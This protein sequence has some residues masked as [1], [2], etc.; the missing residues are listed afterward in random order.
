MF[1]TG[2]EG[3]ARGDRR[4]R[5]RWRSSAGP[6]VH[7]RNGVCQ[8]ARRRRRRRRSARRAT[9]SACCRS[10]SASRR[11]CPTRLR[12]RP[13]TR[14]RRPARGAQGLRRPRRRRAAIFDG[15]SLLELCAALGAEHGHRHSPASR[16]GRSA[17]SPTSRSHLGGVIDAAASEK[18]ALFVECVRPL[19]AA[20]RRPRRHS[21]IH[22]RPAA[23]GRGRDPPRRLAAARVRRR[24]GAEVTVVLRKAYGGAVITMN[25]KDLGADVVF[26][27]PGAEIGIMAASPGGRDRPP[28]R[29]RGRGRGRR[30]S[31]RARRPPTPPSI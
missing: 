7:E 27:W 16:A 1:L 15:G 5:S 23:G 3:R 24:R 14:R 28:P 21:R 29:A 13:A 4:R 11:R 10:G 12:R 8:L 6:R 19:R 26:A 31:R 25:S 20:A 22:A 2:P 9:C 18:A 17:W 30:A